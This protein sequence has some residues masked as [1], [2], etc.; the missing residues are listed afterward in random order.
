MFL[1]SAVATARLQSTL[2]AAIDGRESN[3]TSLPSV[4]SQLGLETLALG[5]AELKADRNGDNT[6]GVAERRRERRGARNR[7]VVCDGDGAVGFLGRDGPR[8]DLSV[9]GSEVG[10]PVGLVRLVLEAAA[11][12][13]VAGLASPQGVVLRGRAN[14]ER[15]NDGAVGKL[16]EATLESTAN[17]ASLSV[18]SSPRHTGRPAVT[19]TAAELDHLIAML[20]TESGLPSFCMCNLLKVSSMRSWL[21]HS[22]FSV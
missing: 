3:A 4:D 10:L 20:A 21:E 18:A 17:A 16:E 1:R 2:G 11:A 15:L 22:A 13:F 14:S 8:H 9:K 12:G 5:V 7:L 6:E 19:G